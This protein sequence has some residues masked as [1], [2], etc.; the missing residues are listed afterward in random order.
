M[1]SRGQTGRQLGDTPSGMLEKLE[2]KQDPLIAAPNSTL[3]A[4]VEHHSRNL[5]IPDSI[6]ALPPLLYGVIK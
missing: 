6:T 5:S 1:S 2:S 4:G 3:K